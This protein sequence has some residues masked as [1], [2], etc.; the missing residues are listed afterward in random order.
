MRIGELFQLNDDWTINSKIMLMIEGK[1][2]R[3][4]VAG[5]YCVR[6]RNQKVLH[7]W[8]NMVWV[9]KDLDLQ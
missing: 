6:H 8:R 2:G 3:Y 7:F 4:V 5:S 9:R 1:G